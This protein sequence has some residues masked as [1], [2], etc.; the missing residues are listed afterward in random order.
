[1]RDARPLVFDTF[2]HGCY[3]VSFTEVLGIKVIITIA[4]PHSPQA[5]LDIPQYYMW[6]VSSVAASLVGSLSLTCEQ[7]LGCLSRY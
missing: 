3:R 7:I 1:M 2:L 4:N 5:F 6:T